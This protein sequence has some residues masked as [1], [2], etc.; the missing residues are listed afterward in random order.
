MDKKWIAKLAND[1]EVKHGKGARDRIFGD[2]NNMAYTPECLSAWFDNFTTGMDE[3]NDKQFLQQ[4]MAM[5]CPCGGNHEDD[6]KV[7]R[8]FYGKSG[9]ISAKALSAYIKTVYPFEHFFFKFVITF[10]GMN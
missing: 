3:L 4:M 1:I 8:D 9:N 7:M 10:V 6:G 2:I 5:R